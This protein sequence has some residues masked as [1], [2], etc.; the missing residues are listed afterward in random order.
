MFMAK[1]TK[2]KFIKKYRVKD[3]TA[4]EVMAQNKKNEMTPKTTRRKLQSLMEG[5][6]SEVTKTA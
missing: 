3:M 1:L 6:I 5:A 2:A 4:A